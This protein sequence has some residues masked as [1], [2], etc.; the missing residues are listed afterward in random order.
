MKQLINMHNPNE[1]EKENM[2]VSRS[3]RGRSCGV[4]VRATPTVRVARVSRRVLRLRSKATDM[5]EQLEDAIKEAKDTC[6]DDPKKADCAV[7]WD[8]VEEISA[9]ISHKKQQGPKDPLEDFCD[10]NPE[11]DE[12]R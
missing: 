8:N 3:M 5:S 2:N 10:D 6:E 1:T 4:A 12:C 9:E 11:A 7:A